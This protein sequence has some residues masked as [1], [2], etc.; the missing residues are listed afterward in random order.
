MPAR[1]ATHPARRARDFCGPHS[2]NASFPRG[3]AMSK[4][5][6]SAAAAAALLAAVL[7]VRGQAQ[8]T[9]PDGPGKATVAALCESCHTFASRVGSGYKADGW[10]TVIRMMDNHGVTVPKDQVAVVTDYL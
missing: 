7:P 2:T 1:S 4:A 8:S 5:S 6:A 9:L 3:N 10:R